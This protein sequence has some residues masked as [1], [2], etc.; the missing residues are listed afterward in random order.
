MYLFF[1]TARLL[2]RPVQGAVQDSRH[3]Q[4]DGGEIRETKSRFD[5]FPR[6]CL[7]S[8]YTFAMCKETNYS[9]AISGDRHLLAGGDAPVLRHLLKKAFFLSLNVQ[10]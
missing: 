1:C 7:L 6:V 10:Y 8:G 5:W 9:F 4:S 2:R 3:V